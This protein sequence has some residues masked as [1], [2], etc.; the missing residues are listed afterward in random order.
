MKKDFDTWNKNK[1]NLHA[2]TLKRF[3][4]E[5]EVWWCSLGVNV[6]F[7]QDGTG[8]NFDR[9]VV[10]LKGLSQETCLVVPLTTSGRKHPLR[11]SVG[12]IED[13]D[14]VALISQIRVIDTRRLIRKIGFL[15]PDAFTN[16][17]DAVKKML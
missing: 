13:K 6:G 17:R 11:I 7:E 16:V 3:C 1:K 10:V 15:A 4:H 12:L 14:A 5:R 9:P 8:K 2:S